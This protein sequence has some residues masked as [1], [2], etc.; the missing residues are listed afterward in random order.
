[1]EQIRSFP[2][3]DI[4]ISEDFKNTEPAAWK[5]QRKIDY[6]EETRE[7]PEDIVINDENVLIDGYTTYLLAARYRLTHVPVK[8]GYVELIEARHRAGQKSYFWRV[9][10]RLLGKARQGDKCI[11]RTMSGD[12]WVRVA[13][14]HRIQ[15]PVQEVQ[16]KNVKAVIQK[17]RK[18]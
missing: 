1:M 14:V 18:S 10:T 16:L 11:V 6:Y 3:K 4:I 12:K 2:L 8:R 13:N 9:P 17:N 15:Y 7:L 5:L